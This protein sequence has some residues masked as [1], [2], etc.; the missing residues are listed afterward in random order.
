MLKS[1]TNTPRMEK[2]IGDAFDI[3]FPHL[4]GDCNVDFEHGQWWVHHIFSGAAW[5]VVD[6]EGPGSIYGFDFEQVSE[7]DDT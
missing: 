5:S 6:A 7:G 4:K 1:E 2:L 3:K